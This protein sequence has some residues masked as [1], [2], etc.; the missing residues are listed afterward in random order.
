M[1]LLHTADWHVGKVLKGVERLGEQREVLAEIVALAEREAVDVVLVAG[2][3]FESAAPGAE[4]QG[5]AWATLLALRATGADVVVVAGNHDPAE[6]FDAWAPVFAGAGITMLGRPRRPDEGGVVELVGRSTGEVLRVALLPFVSQRGVV[7]AGELLELDAA[8]MAGAYAERIAAVVA[9]LTAGFTVEAVNVVV[10]HA[11][12]RGGVLGGGE[13]DAQ[14]IFEYSVPATVFPPSASYVA[15]G[16]LHRLQQLPAPAPV[17][18]PG[19]PIA[20]DFGEEADTKHVL[21]VEA[22]PGAPAKVRAVPLASPRV[23]RTVRGTVAELAA[24]APDLGDALLRVV[25][26]ERARA[27][28]ADEVRHV[29]PNALEVRV[30][31]SDGDRGPGPRGPQGRTPH[32]LFAAYLT[33]LEIDDPRLHSLFADLLDVE[34]SRG[35]G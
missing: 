10:A 18:Y 28:L 19:S 31:R 4:V 16:H 21:V 25:V 34:L 20:V 1:K 11:T 30:E 23:L 24:Q 15:L 26:T 2:D 8:Q 22:S 14:T 35:S 33:E 13:R 9:A 27:G 5:L 29:L 7:R 6:W 3:V 32:E 12:V 17:W